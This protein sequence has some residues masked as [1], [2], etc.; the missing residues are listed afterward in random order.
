MEMLGLRGV[1]IRKIRQVTEIVYQMLQ[2]T[3]LIS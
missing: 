2:G 1:K 3:L